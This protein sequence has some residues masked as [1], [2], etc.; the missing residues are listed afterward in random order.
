MMYS[1]G[2]PLEIDISSLARLCNT[3]RQTADRI[4]AKLLDDEKLTIK[5][6]GL[7]NDR[8]DNEISKI[9]KKGEKNGQKVDKNLNKETRDNKDLQ[10]PL[11]PNN[12]KPITNKELEFVK[13]LEKTIKPQ[14][15]DINTPGVDKSPPADPIVVHGKITFAKASKVHELVERYDSLTR[16]QIIGELHELISRYDKKLVKDMPRNAGEVWQRI[17]ARLNREDRRAALTIKAVAAGADPDRA[18][19]DVRDSEY[20][21]DHEA[22]GNFYGRAVRSI[23][24]CRALGI[25][26]P[27]AWVGE[28]WENIRSAMPE[29]QIA[30]AGRSGVYR[31]WLKPGFEEQ[32]HK[33]VIQKYFDDQE[34]YRLAAPEHLN[35]F[36]DEIER[37]L[38]VKRSNRV[39][40]W[41]NQPTLVDASENAAMTT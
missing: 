3:S 27:E 17:H 12:H 37:E 19:A 32:G 20:W 6:G 23:I 13:H 18:A 4:I 5:D 41:W 34:E 40:R 24:A 8:V 2:K 1:K 30:E 29:K 9:N 22:T 21:T 25:E 39:D 26:A 11:L 10:T 14:N 15:K 16:G 31:K 35:A 7:W 33:W 28:F 36:L 38:S